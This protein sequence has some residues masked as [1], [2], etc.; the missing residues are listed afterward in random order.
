MADKNHIPQHIPESLREVFSRHEHP[1]LMWD[2]IEN[3]P[4]G[5]E[6]VLSPPSMDAIRAAAAAIQN[7]TALHLIGCGTSY[8]AGIAAS[9]AFQSLAGIPA[10]AVQ[11]FEYLAYPPP[12]SKGNSLIGISHTGTTPVI[13]DAVDRH[14]QLGGLTV[15]ITDER[16][17]FLAQSAEFVISGKLGKEPALPKTRSYI[18]ALLRLYLLVLESS[19][20]KGSLDPNLE[21]NLR[22][23][24]EMAKKFIADS[25]APVNEISASVPPNKRVVIAAGGPNTATAME[26][27]LKLIEAA[28]IHGQ[29]WEI[30]EA[31][32]GT[33]ASTDPGDWIIM[34]A[35]D[36]PSSEKTKS[37]FTGLKSIILQ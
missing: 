17:S 26:G 4:L 23:S 12:F 21:R 37:I 19:R 27:A 34:L 20:L 6:E 35:F 8:F 9:Y 33:W 28:L 29:A 24:P 10:S 30:E 36:G 5:M 14:R 31:A 15:G 7:S 32:H 13:I 18:A 22:R 2:G 1:Y 11:A 3:I 25:I 16:N